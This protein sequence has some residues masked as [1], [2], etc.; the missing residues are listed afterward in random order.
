MN[1]PGGLNEEDLGKIVI[2]AAAA[3]AGV[4][5]VVFSSM[6]SVTDLTK[7]AVPAISFDRK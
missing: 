6:I 4:K 7:G 1:Q 2:D 3:A 5:H